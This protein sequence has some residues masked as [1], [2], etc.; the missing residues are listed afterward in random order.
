[1]P[2]PQSIIVFSLAVIFQLSFLAFIRKKDISTRYL[3]SNI[4]LSIGINIILFIVAITPSGGSAIL[5]LMVRLFYVSLFFL[6]SCFLS[7]AI[8]TCMTQGIDDF[9]KKI[10]NGIWIVA[11]CGSILSVFTDEIVQGYKPFAFT[12]T[13]IQGDNYWRLMVHGVLAQF[14]AAAIL[15]RQRLSLPSGG[16]KRR[17]SITLI[18]YLGQIISTMIVVT[19]MQIGLEISLATTLPFT[20]TIFLY[21]ILYAEYRYAWDTVPKLTT[22]ETPEQLE[23]SENDQ[24]IE[25]FAKYTAGKYLFNE[26]T[27][28]IDRLL[29]THMYNK[30]QGNMLRTARDMGLGRST[31]YRKIEKH[32]LK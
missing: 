17:Y 10:E 18:A 5:E 23:M 9:T 12:I 20:T 32:N 8:N 27:E 4:I 22:K 30:N 16:Q 11:L 28:K 19:M 3:R 13:A 6:S 21:L 2:P 15:I 25:I 31:L 29:L 24:L 26:A 14:T 7:Y 1:M